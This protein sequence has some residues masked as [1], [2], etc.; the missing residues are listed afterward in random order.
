M[1][2]AVKYIKRKGIHQKK[3]EQL[4]GIF[5]TS[6]SHMIILALF[7]GLI[8]CGLYSRYI[9]LL[10]IA[11][12]SIYLVLSPLG[13][14]VE[15]LFFLLAFENVFKLSASTSSVFTFL[16]I[17]PLCKMIFVGKKE[18]ENKISAIFTCLL[19]GY[20]VFVSYTSLISLAKFIIGLFLLFY[21]FAKEGKTYIDK[22]NVVLIYSFGIIISSVWALSGLPV[23][24]RY[25]SSVIVRLNDGSAITRF[26]GLWKN[27][28]YYS[29][30]ISFALTGL[31]IL[32]L[33]NQIKY[34]FAIL[35]LPLF[36][37]GS[38]SQSKT[39]ILSLVVGIILFFLCFSKKSYRSMIK[40]VI[41]T[42]GIYLVFY[43]RINSFIIT[44]FS[45]VNELVDDSTTLT[46]ATTGRSDIWIRYMKE[47]TTDVKS[48]LFGK[49]MDTGIVGFSDPHN[50]FIEL[51]YTIGFVGT[52]IYFLTICSYKPMITDT[53]YVMILI[54]IFLMRAFA[55]NIAYYNNTWY[56]Y[57]IIFVLLDDRELVCINDKKREK[58]IYIKY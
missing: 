24:S 34:E 5:E 12:I 10:A 43:N 14:S 19:I 49:G 16:Q 28:N 56:Y 41:V 38:M 23:L 15:D 37:L 32:F 8:V 3:T 9:M 47:I 44:Y 55:A 35:G 17:I 57:A 25:I 39:F 22:K 29:M 58:C 7:S 54:F 2:A 46:V 36:I 30:E 13:R 40:L 11:V 48:I 26:S 18:V 27:A 33:R 31:A 52:T 50:M 53:R 21:V 42:I 20:C 45:R 6:I 1:V 51:L 4:Q